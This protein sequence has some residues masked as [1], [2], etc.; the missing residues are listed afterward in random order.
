VKKVALL[1]TLVVQFVAGAFACENTTGPLLAPVDPIAWG[2]VNAD[3]G[4]YASGG[5]MDSLR[6]VVNGQLTAHQAN[7]SFIC[8]HCRS[9]M[10]VKCFDPSNCVVCSADAAKFG[11]SV[12]DGI[13]AT[14]SNSQAAQASLSISAAAQAFLARQEEIR[15]NMSIASKSYTETTTEVGLEGE[16]RGEMK[17]RHSIVSEAD[18]ERLKR[19]E[20]YRT[21]AQNLQMA[22]SGQSQTGGNFFSTAYNDVV[23]KL[24]APEPSTVLYSGSDPLQ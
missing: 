9:I 22:A 14:N 8:S 4:S 10:R 16:D 5:Q 15:A 19:A 1:L 3:W 11:K 13:N 6:K 21:A 24:K 12:R 2:T 18:S 7:C 23:S 17:V 20:A